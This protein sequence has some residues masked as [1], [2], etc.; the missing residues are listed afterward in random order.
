[1]EAFI[2]SQLVLQRRFIAR[3]CTSFLCIL[4]TSP[5]QNV[6]DRGMHVT[7]CGKEGTDVLRR[8]REA[9]ILQ[10]LQQTAQLEVPLLP[11]V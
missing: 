2:D 3:L 9:H 7:T 5:V 6:F 11:K 8:I 4:Y 1:M 10:L